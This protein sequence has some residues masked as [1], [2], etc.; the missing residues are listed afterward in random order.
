MHSG[1]G[2]ALMW[3]LAEITPPAARCPRRL[4]ALI[5]ESWPVKLNNQTCN[6]L[7]WN[8]PVCSAPYLCL[9]ST[10]AHILIPGLW[11]GWVN[12]N[13][14]WLTLL[15]LSAPQNTHSWSLCLTDLVF[16]LCKKGT[17]LFK[18]LWWFCLLL[19]GNKLS[20]KCEIWRYLG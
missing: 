14:K 4:S 7:T 15:L 12:A 6:N 13:S 9:S 1:R 19:P 11:A 17:T 5:W 10:L 3:L 18:C 2:T 20:F 8:V 16:T